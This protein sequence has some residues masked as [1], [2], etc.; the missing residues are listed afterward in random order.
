MERDETA[1]SAATPNDHSTYNEE[2]NMDRAAQ[3]GV[4]GAFDA[5]PS[6]SPTR[7]QMRQDAADAYGGS[8]D[9]DATG[10]Q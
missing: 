4:E 7:E 8:G 3:A 2:D 6:E 10:G 5:D 1:G 9:V